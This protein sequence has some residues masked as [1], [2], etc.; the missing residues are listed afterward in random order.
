LLYN[1]LEDGYAET[2]L[3]RLHY[4]EH[5]GTTP[6]VL[7]LHG[8]G[9]DTRVWKRLVEKLPDNLGV[10]LVDLLGH[11]ESD[12]PEIEYTP[13]MHVSVVNELMHEKGIEDAFLFGHSYGAWVA[14][15]I[16]QESLKIR[17]LI[18]EDAAGLKEHFE[19]LGR[20]GDVEEIKK[21]VVKDSL[22]TNTNE[23]VIK[24][25]VEHMFK[26]DHLTK[27]M[28]MGVRRPSLVVWG[29][30]D[31][32]VNVKYASIFASYMAGSRLEIIEGAGHNPHFT[33]P[34]KVCEL[35]LRFI[36]H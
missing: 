27:E 33:N 11:G 21:E 28:L 7:F 16:A 30:C 5:K 4:K 17:G 1:N 9:A 23:P 15:L 24:N 6:V 25:M 3:G 2:R 19:D 35:L 36:S 34:D 13:S 22:L 26:D 8:I 10:C 14:A 12:A 29:E 32:T 31:K 20:E 18:L